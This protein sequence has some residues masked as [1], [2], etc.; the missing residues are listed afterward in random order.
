MTRGKERC[1]QCGSKKIAVQNT[2]K[3]CKVCGYQWIGKV[4][5]KTP[6]KDKTRF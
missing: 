6:R 2:S 5:K 1:P 4:Q 3:K